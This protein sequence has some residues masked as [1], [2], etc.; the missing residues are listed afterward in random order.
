M[1]KMALAMTSACCMTYGQAG[2]ARPVFE[3]AS[4]KPSQGLGMAG[5]RGGAG[6]SDPVRWTCTNWDL[7]NILQA[8]YGIRTYQ[9]AAPSWLHDTKFD[10]SAKVPL[11]ATREQFRLMLQNLLEDR[12]KL[13]VHRDKKEM[14]IYELVVAIGGSKLKEVVGE[15][16]PGAPGQP[17]PPKTALDQDGFPIVPGGTGLV[18]VDGKARLQ[19]RRQTKDNIA[20]MLFAQVGR[21]VVDATGLT[22]KYYALTLSWHTGRS[23][24]VP[25]PP[26]GT[27][28]V[29]MASVPDGSTIFKAIQE[30]LGLKLEPKKRMVEVWVVDKIEK[31]PTEN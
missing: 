19:F 7:W 24:A 6:T 22:G 29:P 4:I 28:P 3:V 15:L 2:D 26:A 8:A 14:S 21:P 18:E 11:G 12:F 10:I 13:A 31:V 30:Q 9:L 23:A 27:Y 1:W 16:P 25:P 5:P 17:G 20:Y